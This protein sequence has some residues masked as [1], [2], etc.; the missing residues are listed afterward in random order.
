MFA[1]M[2]SIKLLTFD[3]TDV[4]LSARDSYF[5]YNDE[6]SENL[7]IAFGIT[8]Y[9]NNQE[10]I[11]DPSYGVLNPYY[12]TWGFEDS[13]GVE[14][15]PLKTRPC[16]EAELHINNQTDP[17]S[18]FYPPHPEGVGSL[19][20]YHKKLKCLDGE[21][22]RVQGDYNSAKTRSFV[23]LFDKCNQTA[24]D[25]VCKSEAE[26]KTWLARKFIILNMNKNRFST[27]E[28]SYDEKVTEESRFIYIAISS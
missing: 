21:G 9:D 17:D 5:D 2:Q 13:V 4:M 3:E 24:F 20:F 26:I 14:F 27:R 8:A 25:G 23:L 18:I 28:Y 12:K 1:F 10:I 19:S 11:E 15:E 6:Y 7:A 22:I 16:T